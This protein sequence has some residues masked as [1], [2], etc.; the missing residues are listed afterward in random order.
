MKSHRAARTGLLLAV[1]VTLI[2]L[3]VLYR[4]LERPAL[5]QVDLTG[6]NQ[7]VVD[8]VE[9]AQD[10]VRSHPRSS[11]AWGEL[12]MVLAAHDFND[13]ALD[14]FRQA[15]LLDAP[16]FRWPYLQAVILQETEPAAAVRLYREAVQR[17]PD[18]AA[19][20]YRLGTAFLEAGDPQRAMSAFEA[21]RNA[22]PQSPWPLI[23]LARAASADGKLQEAL[24]YAAAAVEIDD[25]SR[26]ARLE[27]ARICERLGRVA[28]AN[29]WFL[30]S[31]GLPDTGRGMPDPVVEAMWAHEA[32]GA[33]DARKCQELHAQGR[34]QEA[35]VAYAQLV[36]ERPDLLG[37]RLGLAVLYQQ[38]GR[39][40][41]A[42]AAYREI[43]ARDP[44]HASAWY[45]LATI[46]ADQGDQ[47]AAAEA[48]RHCIA[49]K[50]DYVH[51]LFGL[52]LACQQLQRFDE[53][54]SRFED[55]VKLA[56]EFAP[57]R[58]QLGLELERAGDLS[59]AVF[60]FEH[61]C[62]LAPDQAEPHT[63]LDR[64]TADLQRLQRPA[65]TQTPD[66]R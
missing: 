48:Y 40:R 5:P 18:R 4:W 3:H 47:D 51:A 37:P 43:V 8:A 27:L 22:A 34:L 20:Q 35:E 55:A 53:A 46:F 21:S 62:R 66:L 30:E 13:A 17:R 28:E 32:L 60:Q 1:P 52:G 59:G 10:Q 61:A 49:L 31:E 9:E 12:A 56:P 41:Q 33:A 25:Y 29:A 58:L 26:S 42:I 39:H 15:G 24:K 2:S 50:P 11:T 7:R 65:E 63:H 64:V 16:D 57:A 6:A 14:C 23:G 36:R 54:R 44:E 45:N 19:L 38:S